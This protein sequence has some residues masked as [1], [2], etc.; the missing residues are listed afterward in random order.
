MP[1]RTSSFGVVFFFSSRNS[2]LGRP[3]PLYCGRHDPGATTLPPT[4]PA[5]WWG[6]GEVVHLAVPS[7][8]TTVSFTIMQF[9]D[10]WMVSHVSEEA[11]SAQLAGG[12]ASFTCIC[13]FIGLLSC[14]STFASQ[15]LGAGQPE[16][17]ALYGWQGVWLSLAAAAVAGPPHSVGGAGDGPL[18]PRPGRPGPG[19]AVLPDPDRAA[20]PPR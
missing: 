9:V 19:G 20:P 16:R 17:A 6:V 13:F 11:M 2:A 15:Y 3:R 8:L 1:P 4:D 7:V 18:R 5:R 10:G 12:M 14:V